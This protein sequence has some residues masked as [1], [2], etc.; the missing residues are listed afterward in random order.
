VQ[1][2]PLVTPGA[3]QFQRPAQGFSC[4]LRTLQRYQRAGPDDLYLDFTAHTSLRMGRF[5]QAIELV[6]SAFRISA[7]NLEA[8]QG[9]L[10]ALNN[11]IGNAGRVAVKLLQR[12]SPAPDG[13]EISGGERQPGQPG[14]DFAGELRLA[15]LRA[16]RSK[17]GGCSRLVTVR[18]VNL[19]QDHGAAD[20]QLV[21]ADLSGDLLRLN[22]HFLYSLQ[23]ILFESQAG[24]TSERP[25][26]SPQPVFMVDRGGFTRCQS[27]LVILSRL[28]HIRHPGVDITES[29]GGIEQTIIITNSL[30][31]AAGGRESLQS[32]MEI[33]GKQVF[34]GSEV[35]ADGAPFCAGGVTA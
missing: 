14:L 31:Q 22:R 32:S 21:R 35:Q 18:P 24:Q 30:K 11:P 13:C 33:P 23:V 7:G 12:C 27:L 3:G 20:Q 2:Q 28:A 29:G 26:A 5:Q 34:P 6:K 16:E 10:F 15:D 9:Q 17:P 1:E 4:L 25:A 19:S 8:R